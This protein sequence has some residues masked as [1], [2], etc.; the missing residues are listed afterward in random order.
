M[1]KYE[2]A[3]MPSVVG[4]MI[5]DGWSRRQVARYLRVHPRTLEKWERCR[6]YPAVRVALKG[7]MSPE[8][9]AEALLTRLAMGQVTIEDTM[10]RVGGK[11]VFHRVLKQVPPNPAAVILWLQTHLPERW[12]EA[13]VAG[14]DRWARGVV[15]GCG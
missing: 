14:M 9:T 5:Q 3:W 6:R 4:E 1:T 10:K 8:E 11:T 2:A 12:G 15:L 13:K 7:G